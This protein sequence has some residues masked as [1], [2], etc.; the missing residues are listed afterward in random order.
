MKPVILV[1]DCELP[2]ST[3]L[4]KNL[5]HDFRIISY[6]NG[7]EALNWIRSGNHADLLIMELE[8]HMLNGYEFANSIRKTNGMEAVHAILLSNNVERMERIKTWCPALNDFLQK[9]MNPDDLLHLV[10]SIFTEAKAA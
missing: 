8:M 6:S 10:R 3:L 4:E 2:V 5:S 1:I 7:Y 9:P